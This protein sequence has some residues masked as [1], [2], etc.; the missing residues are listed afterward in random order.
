M[1]IR[2]ALIVGALLILEQAQALVLAR[3]HVL[4]SEAVS[5][6]HAAGR[7]TA[8]PAHALVDLPPFRSSAMDGFGRTARGAC[9]RAG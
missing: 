8:E 7:V 2:Y 3:A 1:R 4:A 9:A 6:Q 5:V